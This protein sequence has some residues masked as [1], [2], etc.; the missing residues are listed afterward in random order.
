MKNYYSTDRLSKNVNVLQVGTGNNPIT[1]L[2]SDTKKV[3]IFWAKKIYKKIT[4][5]EHAFKDFASTYNIEI[6]NSLNPELQ[7]KDTEFAIKNKLKKYILY[8]LR[9]FKFVTTLVLVFKKIESD[10]KEEFDK[11][12]K[13]KQLSM[14]VTLMMCLNQSILQWY[15]TYKNL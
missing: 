7:L 13:P 1:P 9:W 8:E 10:D 15:Q 6:L 12:Q 5:R 3:K 14:K 4:K 11:A 2:C